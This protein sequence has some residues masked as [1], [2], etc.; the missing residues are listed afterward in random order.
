MVA[1]DLERLARDK[2]LESELSVLRERFTDAEKEALIAD[3]ALIY[4][5]L[6]ESINTQKYSRAEEEKPS[7]AYITSNE[8]RLIA[9]PS[10]KIEIAIYPDPEEAFVP[11]SF[12]Q[13]LANQEQIVADDAA[14]L[15]VRLG[16]EGLGQIIPDEA[17]TVTDIVFQH[18]EATGQWL[19]GS[20]HAAAQ[21]L[22]YVYTRT[23]NPV[24]S[25]GSLVAIV[26]FAE[27]VNGVYVHNW[28]RDLGN[29][30]IGVLRMVVPIETK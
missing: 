22:N 7:F 25:P 23:K 24:H 13:R 1:G 20:E 17:S 11:G 28:L 3:G 9:V 10:K 4:T 16:Q 15:R 27:P 6:G 30:Y 12:S 29:R 8:N 5:P 2:G 21:G 26:G 18:E 19:L 14:V